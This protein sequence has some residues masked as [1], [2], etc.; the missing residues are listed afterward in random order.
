MA[1]EPALELFALQ[2]EVVDP[3]ALTRSRVAG[4]GRDRVDQPLVASLET[5]HQRV[6]PR[7]RRARHHEQQTGPGQSFNLLDDGSNTDKY[8]DGGKA[9]ARP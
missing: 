4:R 6:L 7:T 9:P 5:L 1:G 2:E 8:E 3:F